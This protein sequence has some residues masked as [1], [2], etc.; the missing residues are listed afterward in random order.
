MGVGCIITLGGD[1]TNRAVAKGCGDV[2]ILPISTGTNNVFPTMIEGTVAGQAAG[3]VATG[4]VDLD[5]ISYRAKRLEIYF[6][7]EL[8]DIA[9]IDVVTSVDLWLGTRAI[10]DMT[11]IKEI[12]LSRAEPGAIGLSSI[13]SC[14]HTLEAR[15]GHGLYLALGG[16]GT[17]VLAPVGPGLVSHVAVR[18]QQLL[19]L[20]DEVTLDAT[21]GT[22]AV[23]GERQIEV[24]GRPAIKVRLTDNGPRVVELRRCMEEATRSG[25]FGRLGISDRRE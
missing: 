18:K 5:K 20:G 22:V 2:P 25:V 14:F 11:H 7:N 15:D 1:G 10:W 3:R 23:D 8:A 13:G 6:D 16:G 21:A 17:Q 19:S 24:Y 4:A 9:L 12:V